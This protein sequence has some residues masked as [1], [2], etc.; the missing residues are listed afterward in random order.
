MPGGEVPER[1][2]G[3]GD[4]E[5]RVGDDVGA[6]GEAG[7]GRGQRQVVAVRA[8]VLLRR[9]EAL[10]DERDLEGVDPQVGGAQGAGHRPGD[11]GLPDPGQSADHDEHVGL[12][13]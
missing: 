5:D 7:V 8:D 9:D 10:P 11:R 12:L 1:P 13:R 2:A 4:R 3:R 6:G